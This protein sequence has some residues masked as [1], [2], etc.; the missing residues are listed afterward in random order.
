LARVTEFLEFARSEDSGFDFNR[1]IAYPEEFRRLDDIAEEWDCDPNK[2]GQRPRD[3][4]NSGGYEWCVK[5]WGTKWNACRVEV[6]QAESWGEEA[7][8]TIHFA[9]AWSPPLPVIRKAGE[10]FPELYLRLCYYEAG[11]E[12]HGLYCCTNGEVVRD[13]SGRYF[14]NRGG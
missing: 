14:G 10:L 1:F 8:V 3:G 7:E 6:D 12:F 11:M 9:T 2:W 13:E 5:H 4:F